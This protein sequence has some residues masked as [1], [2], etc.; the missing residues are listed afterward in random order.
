VELAITGVFEDGSTPRGARVPDDPRQPLRFVHGSDVVLRVKAVKANG[1]ALSTTN[2]TFYWTI[3][4][5]DPGMAVGPRTRVGVLD[6][7]RGPGEVYFILV[8]DDTLQLEPGQYMHDIWFVGPGTDQ[9]PLVP[10][11]PLTVEPSL[12][13]DDPGPITYP[14]VVIASQPQMLCTSK[15]LGTD[16]VI[17]AGN[18]C[19]K[20]DLLIADGAELFVSDTG[21]LVLI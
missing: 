4:G 11:S 3:R 9:E 18:V 16:F 1:E 13:A 6:V 15:T 19:Y 10:L 5:I 17:L 2:R 14:P 7:M 12:Y 20:T 21:E 8:A